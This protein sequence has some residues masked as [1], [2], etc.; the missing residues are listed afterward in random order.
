MDRVDGLNLRTSSLDRRRQGVRRR[1]RGQ[2]D[3]RLQ[4]R[5]VNSS[6]NSDESDLKEPTG[7]AVETSSTVYVADSGNDR[8]AAFSAAGTPSL[9]SNRPHPVL[10]RDVI[11]GDDGD[12]Y[13]A[14]LGNERVDVFGKGGS[15]LRSI[16]AGTLGGPVALVS[17][18]SAGIYV[19]DQERRTGRALQRSGRLPR[20]LRRRTQCRRGRDRMRR[21]RLRDEE[22]DDAS[23]A[24]CASAN[25][26]LRRRPVSKPPARNR[27][28]APVPKLP[29]NKFHFAGLEK[30]RA[31]GFAV[32][33]VRVPGPG[34]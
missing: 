20:R 31:N 25:P 27:S 5:P 22:S 6:S 9:R 10:A 17:D 28:S 29:S 32:L 26:G 23:P 7:L 14:D 19:A 33:Y 12:L 1:Q 11:V 30:N 34:R 24:S 21:Q 4:L 15:F 3:R 2:P 18:R 8:V 16:G 13:V